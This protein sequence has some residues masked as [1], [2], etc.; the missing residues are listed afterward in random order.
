MIDKS[1]VARIL[2]D[3]GTLLA[4]KG[5]NDFRCR[6]YHNACR[7]IEQYEGD[8]VGKAQRGELEHIPGIGDTLKTKI[9][10]IVTTGKLEFLEKLKKE[11]PAGLV[12]MLKIAGLGPKKIAVLHQDLNITT[13]AE[14]QKACEAGTIA[15]LKGFGEK[16]QAKILEGIAFLDKVGHRFLIDAAERVGVQLLEL[17]RGVSGVQ[18]SE[19]CGSLRRRKETVA[20]LDV[21]VS[22]RNPAAVMTAF[23]KAP[24]VIQ[25]LVHGDTKSSVILQGGIQADL[26]V[27]ADE[28]FAFALHYFTGSK[29]HNIAM[30]QRAIDQ[31]L[32][33]NE[34]ALEGSKKKLKAHTEEDLFAHLGLEYIPPELRENTGEIAAAEAKKLPELIEYDDL[35]GTLH[36][37]TIAS[38]GAHTLEEMALAARALGL[39]YLGIGDHSQSFKLANGLSPERIRQQWKQIDTLNAKFQGF[40]LLKG[41]ECDILPDGTLDYPDKMLAAFDYVVASVHTHFTLSREQQTERIIRAMRHPSVDILGHATGRLLLRREGYPLD[42]D[43]VMKVAAETGTVI[44]INAHP[45]RLDL[46]WL[47]VKQAKALGVKFAINPDAHAIDEIALLKYGIDVAR[48]GWLT[49]D[50][51]INTRD[52]N[53][54]R[55]LL[56][57]S[58]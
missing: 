26:R 29:E 24:D 10:E 32:R 54:A 16:T 43:T 34:Y 25:V 35:V 15:S 13:V 27:V 57:R 31:G 40:Q 39:K 21:L 23:V 20:D 33:L 50:D 3:C 47:H 42:L 52:W 7:A 11:I 19:L 14:L 38:D 2:D 36:C 4:L 46:D 55:A 12:E 8:F 18:R 30:R 53:K 56:K 17:V 49:K 28:S 44:E 6:A 45:A 5:E 58:R 1:Q 37:H 9:H 48:R 41:T 22:A 51:V